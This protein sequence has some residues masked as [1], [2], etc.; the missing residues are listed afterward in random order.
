MAVAIPSFGALA[1]ASD[2]EGKSRRNRHHSRTGY[3][4][5]VGASCSPHRHM[6]CSGSSSCLFQEYGNANP[7]QADDGS[8]RGPARGLLRWAKVSVLGSVATDRRCRASSGASRARAALLEPWPRQLDRKL[9]RNSTATRQLLDRI[10]L[11]SSTKLDS[12]STAPR[13]CLDGA[14]RL[15]VHVS[16]VKHNPLR[17]GSFPL[18]APVAARKSAGCSTANEASERASASASSSISMRSLPLHNYTP[19]PA[20][21]FG[22]GTDF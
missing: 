5:R 12:Y 22:L 9:D 19:Q 3:K 2:R 20:W 21:L 15:V 7:I 16:V 11:D 13:Q 14:R 18:S 8:G 1:G 6:S 10:A 17:S 4:P